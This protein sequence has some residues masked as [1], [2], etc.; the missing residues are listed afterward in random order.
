MV[1]SPPSRDV[2][3]AADLFRNEAKGV[4]SKGVSAE[5]SVTPKETENNQ[6]NWAQQ[7]IWHSR[8]PQPREEYIFVKAPCFT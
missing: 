7:Y 1:L 8:A 2:V 6:G 3:V 5:S 4:L